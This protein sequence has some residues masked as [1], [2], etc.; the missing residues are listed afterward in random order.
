M[1][2]NIQFTDDS[3]LLEYYGGRIAVIRGSE[4]NIKITNKVDLLLARI[5]HK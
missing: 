5:I 2:E 4:N 3:A 1:K